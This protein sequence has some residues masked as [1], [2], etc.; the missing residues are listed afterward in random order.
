MKGA[1]RERGN[2]K[3]WRCWE[4]YSLS[5]QA[6]WCSRWPIPYCRT[7]GLAEPETFVAHS[8]SS[9]PQK[10][11]AHGSP[12]AYQLNVS[13][14]SNTGTFVHPRSTLA[15]RLGAVAIGRATLRSTCK[16]RS[17]RRYLPGWLPA[18]MPCNILH[19]FMCAYL[20]VGMSDCS[21]KS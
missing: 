19:T 13:P 2:T 3:K 15:T 16:A 11:L 6:C 10:V 12:S 4:G 17:M 5:C 1:G 18:S 21:S 14:S 7:G 9:G 20:P 8:T